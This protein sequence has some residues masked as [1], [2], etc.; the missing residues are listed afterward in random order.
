M[1]PNYLAWI[2]TLWLLFI[3]VFLAAAAREESEAAE[4]AAQEDAERQ[5]AA[6]QQRQQQEAEDEAMK[7]AAE[8]I[9]RYDWRNYNFR[10]ADRPEVDCHMY[11]TY[12]PLSFW[13][14]DD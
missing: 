3:A 6:E 9:P 1:M 14:F 5:A 11:A 8:I 13:S 4:A 10:S 7:C 2:L 12:N